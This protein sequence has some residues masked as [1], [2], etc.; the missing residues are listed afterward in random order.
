MNLI[1]MGPPG[2]GKGTQ[3]ALL[4]KQFAIPHI[5]TGD[6]FRQA[7]QQ[8][9]ELGLKA[10]TFMDAGTLVPDEVTIGIVRERLTLPDCAGG[11]LLDGFPRTTV[12]AGALQQLLLDMQRPLNAVVNIQVAD[13]TLIQRL[14]G[15]LVCRQCGFTYHEQ[16][17]PPRVA[18]C[19]DQCGGEVYQ[20]SDDT[21][22][23]VAK[24]LAVYQEQTQPLISF[25]EREGILVAIEGEQAV[26][27]VFADILQGL[28]AVGRK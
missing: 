22:P 9:T 7:M 4:V 13:A 8:G 1:L 20:R 19:C 17:S 14:S 6:M 21:G 3:A 10:K 5:S 25:Y 28:A 15:R 2:A 12:Q 16:F 26:E 23:T 27:K 24:R 18:G 11:F